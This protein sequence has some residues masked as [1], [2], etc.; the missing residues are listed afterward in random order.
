ME[1]FHLALATLVLWNKVLDHLILKSLVEGLFGVDY[2][3]IILTNDKIK[4]IYSVEPSGKAFLC[5]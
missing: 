4:N 3:V 2:D 1:Y 5:Y